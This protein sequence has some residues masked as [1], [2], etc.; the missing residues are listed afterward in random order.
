[1]T[2]IKLPFRISKIREVP[3]SAQSF[4]RRAEDGS[5]E[6][7]LDGEHPDT[8]KLKAVE[9]KLA[10]FRDHNRSLHVKTA[11]L[12][13]QLAAFDGVDVNALQAQVAALSKE[14]T[15][16]TER[17]RPIE[18]LDDIEALKTAAEELPAAQARV[19]E[20]QRALDDRTLDS[21]LDAE[22]L[23]RGVLEQAVEYARLEGRKVFRV[24]EG[25]VTT[26]TP[27]PTRPGQTMTIHEWVNQFA[28]EK[29]F[30]VKPS[31]GAGVVPASG[32]PPSKLTISKYDAEAFGKH[33]EQIAT[34]H[35]RVE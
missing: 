3:E 19:S 34:G 15:A 31:R 32:A 33:A 27:S 25:Q 23:K 35:V 9:Q 20:L 10:E 28:N 2:E 18:G 7:Q 6:L 4:Y 17:L 11:E 29:A 21:A 14:K 22:L 26:E 13:T 1:M 16:L 30:A 12:E 24:A 5:L 8:V